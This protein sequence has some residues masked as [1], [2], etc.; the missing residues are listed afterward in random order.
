MIVRN[1]ARVLGRALRSVRDLIDHWVICDTGSTDG[2]PSVILAELAGIPGELRRTPW[3]DFGHNRTEAMRHARGRADYLLLIDAD[4]VV[5]THAPFKHRL[6]ADAYD[7]RFEGETDYALPLL[8][9]D[10]FEWRYVGATHEYIDAAGARPPVPLPEVTVA[11]LADGGMRADKFERDVRLLMAAVERTPDDP[12]S[13]FYLAQSWRD[14]GNLAEALHWYEARG[15]LAGWDEERWYALYQVARMRDLL[16]HDWTDVQASY[17]AAYA[18]RPWRLEPLYWITRHHR[19]REAY[20]LGHLFS[21]LVGQGITYPA[22]RLFIERPVYRYLLSLEYALC[23]VGSGHP[24][25]ARAAFDRVLA[26][27]DAPDEV[28]D[29]ARRARALAASMDRP[30]G[31]A[32]P[33]APRL[34]A[35]GA[36]VA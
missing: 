16:G 4:M 26:C 24:G 29:I 23:A 3:V 25:E 8:V 14:L 20:A 2:T 5:T 19:E 22:D 21:A 15:R 17:L 30:T 18:A 35:S 27:P 6:A 36:G 11:H 33:T 1:E 31:E 34:A 10:R 28:V 9:A 7:V 13:V 32:A 12:R